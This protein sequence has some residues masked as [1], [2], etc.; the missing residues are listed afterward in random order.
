[1]GKGVMHT[2]QLKKS[3]NQEKDRDASGWDR[4]G[5]K[6]D[7]KSRQDTHILVVES[8]VA[9]KISIVVREDLRADSVSASDLQVRHPN[10]E[11]TQIYRLE[12]NC[13]DFLEWKLYN[14]GK[15]TQG[16]QP[17]ASVIYCLFKINLPKG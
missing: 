8:T 2:K 6:R 15:L 5:R 9:R 1:M 10:Y 3:K 14:V 17:I 12:N 7:E 4:K 16:D 13:S 11:K